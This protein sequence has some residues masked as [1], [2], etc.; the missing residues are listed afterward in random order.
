MEIISTLGLALG[1]AWASGINLYAMVATLGLLGRFAGLDLPG[2]L[3]VVT[4]WWVIGVAGL[5]YCVEFVADKV[6]VVD[7]VWDVV[8]TF[9]RVPAGAVVAAAALGDFSP[10]VQVVA[11]L[12]G[13]GIALSSHGAKASA[14]AAMNLSPEPVS[15]WTA[16]VVEDGLAFGGT[17][18]AVFLPVVMLVVVA[19]A[20]ALTIWLLPKIVR[21]FKRTVATARGMF[22]RRAEVRR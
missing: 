3:D 9:V 4:D 13:G 1:S 2:D 20:V 14:R 21:L 7:S 10:T 15:N 11:F 12:A 16:S 8:H 18:L 5:L 19:V 22:R 6:P 17:L